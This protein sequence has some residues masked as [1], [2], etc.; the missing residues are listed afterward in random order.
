MSDSERHA[1]KPILFWKKWD[2]ERKIDKTGE[3]ER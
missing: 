3:R 2:R 1:E